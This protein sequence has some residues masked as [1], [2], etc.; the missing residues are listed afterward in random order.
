MRKVLAAAGLVAA[1]T[2]GGIQFAGANSSGTHPAP[3]VKP[4]PGATRSPNPGENPPGRHCRRHNPKKPHGN[5]P[6]HPSPKPS[7]TPTATPTPT[8]TPTPAPIT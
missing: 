1:L 5:C 4:S 6:A 8:P 2:F 3:H 7:E